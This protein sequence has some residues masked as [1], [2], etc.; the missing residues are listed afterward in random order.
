MHRIRNIGLYSNCYKTL[1]VRCFDHRP[2]T[3]LIEDRFT[4]RSAGIILRQCTSSSSSGQNG[5]I[6][7]NPDVKKL[8]D[9]VYK[10]FGV[11]KNEKED[12]ATKVDSYDDDSGKDLKQLLS[13]LYDDPD[14]ESNSL[15]GYTEFKDSDATIIYDV[16]EERELL[17][18]VEEGVMKLPTIP[19]KKQDLHSKYED[20]SNTHGER[21]A[22]T[23]AELVNVMERE[24][25]RDIA[26]IKV[27]KERNYVDYMVIATARSNQHIRVTATLIRKL[28][29]LKMYDED[30]VPRIE[31]LD[32]N[33]GW[34]ALDLGNIAVHIFNQGQREYYDIETLW[35]VGPEYDDNCLPSK[36]YGVATL[37]EL[38]AVP[39]S[40]LAEFIPLAETQNVEN[41]VKIS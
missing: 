28:Y 19:A 5:D 31:G 36:D 9:E 33:N 25:L 12:D 41:V 2:V 21:G 16:D 3:A 40:R 4:C 17:R 32:A 22:Y 29:K 10:D 13:E 7:N 34:M 30:C 38:M 37:E 23:L 14:K 27:P 26:V 15:S 11:E 20:I 18:K 24:K 35:L 1:T 8:L 6:K 39:Q